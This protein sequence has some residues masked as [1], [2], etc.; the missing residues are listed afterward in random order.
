MEFVFNLK[1]SICFLVFSSWCIFSTSFE[2]GSCDYSA[3][4]LQFAIFLSA[5]LA[6]CGSSALTSASFICAFRIS[7]AVLT[8]AF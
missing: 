6:N 3:V 1:R 5:I 4:D 2:N 8:F 7:G